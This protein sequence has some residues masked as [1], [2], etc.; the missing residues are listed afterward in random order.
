MKKKKI[1]KSSGIPATGCFLL[2]H[3]IVLTALAIFSREPDDCRFFHTHRPIVYLNSSLWIHAHNC[4]AEEEEKKTTRSSSWSRRERKRLSVFISNPVY[5]VG[6]VG[7]AF[8]K[9]KRF[10][11]I[12]YAFNGSGR[13][14][15]DLIGRV[16]RLHSDRNYP[17]SNERYDETVSRLYSTIS[18]P[19]IS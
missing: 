14:K 17:E 9:N 11:G 5:S 8:D 2:A 13:L 15:T 4:L 19:P 16:Q 3:I 12:I 1:P 7:S 18:L 10:Q 6:S